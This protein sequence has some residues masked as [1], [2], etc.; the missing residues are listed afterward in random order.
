MTVEELGSDAE[1][2]VYLLV[3]LSIPSVPH[4]L[5]WLMHGRKAWWR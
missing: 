4:L 5:P 2:V 1:H 3:R